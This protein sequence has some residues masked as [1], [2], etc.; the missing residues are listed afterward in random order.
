MQRLFS[1]SIHISSTIFILTTKIAL[2]KDF[3]Q[4][5]LEQVRYVPLNHYGMMNPLGPLIHLRMLHVIP[6]NTLF[7]HLVHLQTLQM[8]SNYDIPHS[9]WP[10]VTSQMI[11]YTTNIWEYI[12]QTPEWNSK[13][14]SHNESFLMNLFSN[15]HLHVILKYLAYFNPWNRLL[16]S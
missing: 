1:K 15:K 12:P 8:K 9:R 13:W 3:S 6:K 2:T 14:N 10:G 16:T 7:R 11:T 4:Y 5:K